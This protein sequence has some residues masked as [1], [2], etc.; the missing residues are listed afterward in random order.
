MLL[1][2]RDEIEA[3]DRVLDAARDG[4]SATLVLR[5]E[6]RTGKTTV[7]E[8]AVATA[9]GFRVA[10]TR[11]VVSERD[12]PTPRS[13]RC[14]SRSCRHSTARLAGEG[15]SNADIA[16]Q[17][18]ISSSTVER[19]LAKVFRKLGVASRRQ[20]HRAVANQPAS[21]DSLESATS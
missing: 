21:P 10:R 4:L 7:L 20:L 17:L 11:G 2:H 13:T 12:S 15:A 6:P 19:H 8:H 5:G 9:E 1:D 16:A 18:F 3:L 14:C